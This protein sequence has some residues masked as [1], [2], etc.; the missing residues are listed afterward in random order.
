MMPRA[1]GPQFIELCILLGCDYLEPLRGI[2]PKS[3]L[4]LMKEHGSLREVVAHLRAKSAEKAKQNAKAAVKAAEAEEEG[5]DGGEEDEDVPRSD[6]EREDKAG[7]DDEGENVEEDSAEKKKKGKGKK[8]KVVKKGT[9]G[10]QVPEEWMWEEAKKLFEKPD[11]TPASEIEVGCVG[12][13]IPSSL[14]DAFLMDIS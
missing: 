12:L 4:K 10:V 5:S 1:R 3:A 7:S 9:G 2:G 14:P 6:E 8:A 13:K 11:V